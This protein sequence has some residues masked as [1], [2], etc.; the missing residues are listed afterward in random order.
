M[1]LVVLGHSRLGS[2]PLLPAPAS[3]LSR[4]R[5]LAGEAPVDEE[6]RV[7]GAVAGL[8]A[9]RRAAVVVSDFDTGEALGER[10]AFVEAHE[11]LHVVVPE[12]LVRKQAR[13]GR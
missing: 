9:E 12:Q 10:T 13:H 8:R 1:G 11:L 6:V 2:S 5:G 3:A 4:R 7:A